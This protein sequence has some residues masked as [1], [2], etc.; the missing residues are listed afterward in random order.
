MRYRM[1][2]RMTCVVA[3]LAAAIPAM[4]QPLTDRLPAS[5]MVYVGWSPNAS[6][7]TTATAKML[8]DE[9][10]MGPWRRLFQELIL[11]MPDG[12]NGGERISVHIAPLLMDA[13]QCEGCFALLEIK[14]A[15]RHF[16]PQSVLMIDLGAK[17]K[18][19]EEH[20][21]PIQM[22]MKERVGDRLKMV[23][24]QNS[25]VYTKPDREGKAHVTWGFVGDTFV[26]F[27]GDGAEDFI[28][29]LIAGKIESN[30]KNAPAF[31][32]CVSKVPGESIFTTYLDTQASLIMVRKLIEREGNNDLVF[33]GQNWEKVLSEFGLDNVTGVAEKT[34]IEDKQFVTRSLVRTKGA[35]KGLLSFMA[36]APVDEAM[37]KVIPHDAMAA[38]AVRIDPAKT[39]GQLKA[40]AIN[41]GGDDAKQG[42]TQLEQGAEGLGLPLKTVLEAL[43]D[44]WV[45]YNATSQGGFA[46]TGWTLVANIRDA[47]KFNKTLN[48]LR[49]MIAKGFGGEGEKSRIHVLDADGVKIEYME[50]GRWGAPFSP[51][52]AVV[53]DKFVLSLF[54]QIV[55]D[56]AKHI[57]DGGKSI[58]ENPE[59]AAARKRTGTDGPMVYVSGPEVTKN[60]YPVGLLLI[61]VLNNFGGGFHD[62][63]DDSH[64]GGADLLPSMQRVMQYV[65]HD[66]LAIKTTEDGLLKTRSVTNPLLSPLAW[67]DSPVLWLALGIPSIGAA[68]DTAD[69]ATS[70]ANLRQIG[71]AIQLYSNENKGKFPPDLATLTKGENL[72][73]DAI[74]SPFGP[75]KD[76]KD[77]VLV[78]YGPNNPAANPA[79]G[80]EIIIAYD[81]AALE[82]GDGTNALYADGHVDWVSSELFKKAIED[83][84]KK[85]LLQNAQP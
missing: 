10:F 48:V 71:Q 79:G 34:V 60:L 38:A 32:D 8:A 57:K 25:W 76:G 33:V 7:Q 12:P 59:F 11:E 83:S 29:K 27:M 69:R 80:A 64:V 21:K 42:F 16:N 31:I 9:R 18:T 40:S 52:W 78:S 6:L 44:Q 19:F 22:R 26:A 85:A 67:I 37:M 56:A 51:A 39:Y 43:G 61:S 46:L 50:F 5:T 63:E 41:I 54:P 15:Q 1:F 70:A 75:A 13:A 47:E 17:R 72:P 73:Q 2:A 49:G 81:Q 24:L 53:G 36:Q 20:F 77:I 30:L 28:P 62:V 3:M 4:A 14:Q 58:L 68:E 45:I 74:K 23:K 35:P 82:Q 84:K 65:G 55:E 66:T